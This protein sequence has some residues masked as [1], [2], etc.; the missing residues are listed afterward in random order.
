MDLSINRK[1]IAALIIF[2]SF[3][4]RRGASIASIF[5]YAEEYF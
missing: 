1:N 2:I 5:Q 3:R 4:F